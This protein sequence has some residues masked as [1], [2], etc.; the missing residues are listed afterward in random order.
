MFNS[1]FGFN[2]LSS[3]KQAFNFAIFHA[4]DQLVTQTNHIPGRLGD[5]PHQYLSFVNL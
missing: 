2:L 5:T 4:F 3:G 1:I